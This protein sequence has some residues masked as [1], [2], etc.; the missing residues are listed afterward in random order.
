[1]NA[2]VR[3][4]GCKASV[5]TN[6]VEASVR[7]EPD[8][9]GRFPRNEIIS[10][11]DVNRRF[12]LAEST[13][14]DL[15]FG[16]IIDL[17]GGGA[18]LQ[19]LKMGYGSSAGLPRLRSGIAALTGVHLSRYHAGH[20]PGPVSACLRTLSSG[21]RGGYLFPAFPRLARRLG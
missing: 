18:A 13:A 8:W 17:A 2:R 12:N 14:Q 5:D 19:E 4:Q 15:T 21:R 6:N 11:L 16:E 7:R 9:Q 10:L 3:D 20:G 1:M